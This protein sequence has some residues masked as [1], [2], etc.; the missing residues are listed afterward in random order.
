MFLQG[1]YI[2]AILRL[3]IKLFHFYFVNEFMLPFLSKVCRFFPKFCI[4]NIYGYY[5]Y[6]FLIGIIFL[7]GYAYID[8]F[9]VFG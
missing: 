4:S 5:M 3:T 2:E 1:G 8:L 6:N 7:I 9:F